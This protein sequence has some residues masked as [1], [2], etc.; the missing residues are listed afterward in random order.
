MRLGAWPCVLREGTRAFDAY[1][2]REISERHRHRYEFN[3]HYRDIL[4]EHGMVLSGL[5]MDEMLVEI[6]E[7]QDH[8]WFVATQAHP[9]FRSRPIEAH[10][11]FR[12]FVFA[13]LKKELSVSTC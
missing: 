8:P 11:L 6:I 3:N 2:E 7:L 1:G 12:S 10:P 5:S 9:E 13:A 4:Q